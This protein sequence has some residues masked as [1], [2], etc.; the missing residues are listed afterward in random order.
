MSCLWYQTLGEAYQVLSDP[1]QRQKYDAH[2]KAGI[3]A[4]VCV[5]FVHSRKHIVLK[6]IKTFASKTHLRMSLFIAHSF[7]RLNYWSCSNLCHA[8]WK[9]AF[10]GIHWQACHGI[11]CFLGCFYR[12]WK[13][14]C[15]NVA[16]E[17][18]G[19]LPFASYFIVSRN[20]QAYLYLSNPVVMLIKIQRLQ[21]SYN[22][23]VGIGGGWY[24]LY[25]FC[26]QVHSEVALNISNK[27][28]VNIRDF[29]FYFYL[30]VS[31]SASW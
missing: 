21:E 18:A 7:Q 1:A 13:C 27:D 23:K 30:V 25:A 2:G 4:W 11:Y 12:N 10:W 14:W 3:S 22:R 5:A 9:W 28:I 17:V 20:S 24:L 6:L 19:K 31:S 8:L 29:L 15:K 26:F 16:G